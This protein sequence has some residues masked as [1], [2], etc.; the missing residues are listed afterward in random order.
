MVCPIAPPYPSSIAST[1][2]PDAT[3]HV[4]PTL[5]APARVTCGLGFM[6]HRAPPGVP[7][8]SNPRAG[9]S[10]YHPV[11]VARDPR[12]IHLMVTHHATEFTKHVA[13]ASCFTEPP[14]GVPATSNPRA[15][16]SVYHPVTMARDPRSTHLMV[17]HHATGFIKHVDRLQLSATATP[18]TLSPILTSVRSALAD[19]PLA[20]HY[21][22]VR[23]S[24]I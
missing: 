23:G 21:G 10:V 4:A 13:S 12:S 20:S 22:G 19:P 15:G 24:T 18:P 14:P 1:S 11:T 9:S 16:S 17:T 3:P 7:A 8:T 5:D 6:L 2:E